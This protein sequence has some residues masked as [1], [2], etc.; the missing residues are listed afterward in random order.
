MESVKIIYELQ[1]FVWILLVYGA[2]RML[3]IPYGRN[4]QKRFR[5]RWEQKHGPR[6]QKM[7]PTDP[8]GIPERFWKEL[9]EI[10]LLRLSFHECSLAWRYAD[11]LLWRGPIEVYSESA[12]QDPVNLSCYIL[13]INHVHIY[14]VC[15]GDVWLRELSGFRE[16]SE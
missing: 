12:A 1:G 13:S 6:P 7:K 3:E 4:K 11:N 15:S 10:G 5:R 14:L 8:I 9:K 16:L 2:Y